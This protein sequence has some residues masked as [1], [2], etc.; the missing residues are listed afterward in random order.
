MRIFKASLFLFLYLFSHS[1]VSQETIASEEAL[2]RYEAISKAM[3]KSFPEDEMKT[4]SRESFSQTELETYLSQHFQRMDMLHFIEGHTVLKLEAYLQS[5]NW[6]KLIG[7]PKESSKSY[8]QFFEYYKLHEKDLSANE[9]KDYLVMR[10]FAHSMMAENYANLNMMEMAKIEHQKNLAFTNANY[11]VYYPSAINNYGLFFYWH[12]KELD[13]AL[14]YFKRAYEL[15]KAEFSNH[16]L[17][18][19]IRDNIAD[20]YVDL[21]KYE[22]AQSLYAINFEFYTHVIDEGTNRKDIP[23]LIS[24]G[25][26]LVMTNIELD[27]IED[28]QAVFDKLEIIVNEQIQA[29]QISPESRLEYLRTK[30]KLFFKRNEIDAAYKTSKRIESY[31]DSLREIAAIADSKWQNEFDD[32]TVDRVALNFKIA[33]LEKDSQIKSQRSK[34]WIVGSIS[35]AFIILLLFLFLSRYQHLINS[36]NKQL[37]A[38]KNLENSKLKVNQLHA[39]IKSKERDLSDFAINLIQNQEWASGLAAKMEDYKTSEASNKK[40]LLNDLEQDIKNKI[41][42]DQDTKLFFERLDKLSDAF[43]SQLMTNY[44]NLSKNEIQLCSLIRLKMDSRSIATLQN[45]TN[46]SLNTSR[47]R[48]RKKLELSDDVN[49]DDFINS[50]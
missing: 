23:R 47:Y 38:E 32:I 46:A 42:F 12:K 17:I 27:R 39:E 34:L 6:F 26:Q 7:F 49:L 35:S 31:A 1:A 13:S 25:S 5:G 33:E 30:E 16:I 19:S 24:A 29:N 2:K 11:N 22:E 15:T 4:Y 50:L 21:H 20:V 37:I 44:P 41:T 14:V 8:M 36:K 48:L 3:H 43:Y 9:R 28:A 40:D 10:F 45:I 18:G